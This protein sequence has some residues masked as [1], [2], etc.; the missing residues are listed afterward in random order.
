ML[1]HVSP[2]VGGPQC[3]PAGA[4]GGE[5]FG[6]IG[7]A[8]KAF[9]LAGEACIGAVFDQSRGSYRR[10]L[11]CG[12]PCRKNFGEQVRRE[13]RLIE[14]QSDLDRKP[15]LLRRVSIG[16]VAQRIRKSEVLDLPAVGIGGDA[17]SLRR[18][19]AGVSKRC[20]I[21]CFR[22]HAIGVGRCGVMSGY[23]RMTWNLIRR[24]TSHSEAEPRR[25]GPSCFGCDP[26]RLP[27]AQAP[28]DEVSIDAIVISRDRRSREA[29]RPR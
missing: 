19:Q 10:G 4:Q 9:E 28:Q 22:P 6:L 21:R 8:E 18:R 29:D 20:E 7:D 16:V 15:P 14:R 23:G 13:F 2:R 5:E 17:E 11:R 26:S 27:L 1:S 12:A 25:V 24:S 3:R